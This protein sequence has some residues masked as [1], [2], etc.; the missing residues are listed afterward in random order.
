MPRPLRAEAVRGEAI[1]SKPLL[2]AVW[3]NCRCDLLV[4]LSVQFSRDRRQGTEQTVGIVVDPR[5]KE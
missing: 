5:G 2:V 4:I 3:L 1:R